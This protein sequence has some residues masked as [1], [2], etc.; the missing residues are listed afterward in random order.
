MRNLSSVAVLFVS[1]LAAIPACK[2]QPQQSDSP[3]ATAVQA[4][5]KPPSPPPDAAQE[6]SQIFAQKCT[7]CHGSSGRADGPGAAALNPKPR[8]FVDA[9]WQDKVKDD[10]IAKAIVGGGVAVGRTPGMPANPELQAKPEV[11]AELVKIVRK[12]KP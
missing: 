4:A 2:G 6:A 12:F 3:T 7:V 10:E 11:V 1:S 9:A 8:T 5:P